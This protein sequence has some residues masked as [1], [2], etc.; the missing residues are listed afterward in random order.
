LPRATTDLQASKSIRKSA[1]WPGA[2]SMSAFIF[3]PLCT[4]LGVSSATSLPP[5]GTT[6]F[7]VGVAP[8]LGAS[9]RRSCW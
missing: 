5:V 9:T 1:T 4:P 7:A 6:A 8:S 3:S 2:T